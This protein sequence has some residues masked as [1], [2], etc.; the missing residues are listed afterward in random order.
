MARFVRRRKMV[1]QP[2][3]VAE[4]DYK[5]VAT[6]KNFVNESGKIV[7]SRLTGVDAKTQRQLARAIKRARYL[8]LIP[9]TDNQ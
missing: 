1:R 3:L 8:A 9:Y 4:V 2:E 7:A 6:L 5:D